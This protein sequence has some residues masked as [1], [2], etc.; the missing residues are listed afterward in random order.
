MFI[1]GTGLEIVNLNRSKRDLFPTSRRVI[2]YIKIHYSHWKTI[3]ISNLIF[4]LLP[5][6]FFRYL[7]TNFL[8][9][10]YSWAATAPPFPPI[11]LWVLYGECPCLDG[12]SHQLHLRNISVRSGA[13][14]TPQFGKGGT[15]RKPQ[16][17]AK[18]SL[19]F[20]EKIGKVDKA[21]FLIFF[22]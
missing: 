14:L 6:I 1:F 22:W 11:P 5:E 9:I 17:E 15:V 4:W 20:G 12:R 8:S 19:I 16:C 10:T 2:Y 21:D 13:K 7:S 18:R 3:R